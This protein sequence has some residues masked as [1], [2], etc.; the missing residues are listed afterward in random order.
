MHD[1][2]GE[3]RARQAAASSSLARRGTPP[4]SPRLSIRHCGGAALELHRAGE[5]MGPA[6]RGLGGAAISACSFP[7]S[8]RRGRGA[9]VSVPLPPHSSSSLSSP[10]PACPSFASPCRSS[11]H[12][13]EVV[14]GNASRPRG[15]AATGT[16]EPLDPSRSGARRGLMGKCRGFPV[17]RCS[18]KKRDRHPA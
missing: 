2:G 17:P 16:K 4:L 7:C 1:N 14:G 3:G 6:R 15:G 11:R 8:S 18:Q 12:G 13:R 5:R 10:T 9:A